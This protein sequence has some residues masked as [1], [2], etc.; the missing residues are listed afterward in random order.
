MASFFSLLRYSFGNEDWKTEEEALGITPSDKILCI[1]A[2]GDR[3]LN[4]L[5]RECQKMICIDA[6]PVQNYLLELKA[7]AMKALEYKTYIA[8]LGAVPCENRK[9]LLQSV[10]PHLSSAAGQFWI[11]HIKMIEK[12]ILYQ[13]SV[14]RL[15]RI[16]AKLFSVMRGAKIEKLFAMNNLEEQRQFV[17]DHWDSYFWRKTFKVLLNPFISQFFI[18]DPGLL[19]VGSDIK[20]GVYIYERIQDS[21]DRD[22]AKKNPLLSLILKGKVLPDAFS[23]Y[24]TEE[25]TEVIKQRLSSLE[26]HTGNVLDYLDSFSGPEFD[27]F[28]LSDIAS[29]MS[30]PNFVKLLT[31]II[32]TARPGARFCLRQFLSSYEIPAHLKGYFNRDR[33]LEKKLDKQDNCFVYR[34]LVGT[35]VGKESLEPACSLPTD[36]R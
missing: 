28:S 31:L 15:T 34:F 10:L 13:G 24:L 1:T 7:A 32:K 19:N 11:E 35:V 36:N 5:A 12:G 23:P 25:G 14:E 6:N 3:P 8:F 17:R 26:V 33:A 27:C 16:L 20:A 4:L 22:L 9:I 21:L 29:Y 2:S 30:Y 18:K